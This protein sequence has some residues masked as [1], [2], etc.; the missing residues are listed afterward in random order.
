MPAPTGPPRKQR[1][2][3]LNRTAAGG[4]GLKQPQRPAARKQ[5]CC[6]EP[7]I[8]DD[9]DGHQVCRNCFTQISESNIVADVTFQED[10]RGA[11]TVQG[12]FVG[13]DARHGKTM[14]PAGQQIGDSTKNPQ[15]HAASRAKPLI[16]GWCT[17]LGI[18]DTVRDQGIQLFSFARKF[19]CGRETQEVMA[20]CLYAA[21]RR[22]KDNT[23]MLI[24]ISERIQPPVGVF[25]LGEVY[26]EMC[27]TLYMKEEANVGTQYLIEVES[28]VMRYCRKLEFGP[29]TRQ[30]AE[31]AVKIVRRMKRDWMVTGRHPSGLCSACI[32]LAA[33]MNNF[34]RS[35][36]ELVYVAKVAD[37]TIAKRVEEFRRTKAAALTVEQFREYGVRLKHT[38][39]PPV[40]YESQLKK[41]KF[42]DKKRERQEA[43]VAR[44]ATADGARDVI[45]I[46]D[47]ESDDSSREGSTT[48]PTPEPTQNNEGEPSRKRRR[49]TTA[50]PA[51]PAPTQ[52]EPRRD[53]D[54]FLIPALPVAAAQI[55]QQ[56]AEAK[57]SRRG[58]GRPKKVAPEPI[59]ITEEELITEAELEKDIVFSLNDEEIIDS[60]NEIE[61]AKSEERAKTLAEREK[62]SDAEKSRARRE[63]EGITWWEGKE[64]L[65]PEELEAEFEDDPEVQNCLLS[66]AERVTKERIW[67]HNNED[68]LRTQQEKKLVEAIA[69][70][71]GRNEK[72]KKKGTKGGKRKRKGKMGD[73]STLAEATTPIETPHDATEAMLE[74]RAPQISKYLNFQALARIYEGSPSSTSASRQGSVSR[75]PSLAPL[76]P[77]P[78]QGAPSA[79]PTPTSTSTSEPS[80]MQTPPATQVAPAAAVMGAT[81]SPPTPRPTR[82]A[83]P[84][85]P[86]PTQAQAVGGADDQDMEGDDDDYVSVADND[87]DHGSD[88]GTPPGWGDDREDIGEDDFTGAL[89]R[90]GA[91]THDGDFIGD[92]EY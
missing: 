48:G 67:V 18:P 23:I 1:L 9:G 89:G 65:T 43:S 6:N 55:V 45:E 62:M 37:M 92:E 74:R 36:R 75:S 83:G 27:K 14:G 33:R 40:L 42:E 12:G 17:R 66:E 49:T 53:A 84:A 28:L 38:H 85:S 68:W 52:Q 13:Q 4:R 60:R 16:G 46:S 58:P 64:E 61:K 10:S 81:A 88:A 87:L 24:D 77:R 47:D 19:A 3:S 59:V 51:T 90:S 15:S 82:T 25:R 44:E 69:T 91:V 71:A 11:A 79:S 70:S 63:A 50:Q 20:A 29:A 5:T 31:D 76:A 35:V 39:D 30:V 86:P 7:Q 26:K 54:G 34:R 80:R 2:G 73:G 32:I 41:Q 78:L 21:C 56:G 72:G 22:Q 57:K 8:E